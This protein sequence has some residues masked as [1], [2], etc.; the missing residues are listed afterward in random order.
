MKVNKQDKITLYSDDKKMIGVVKK[1]EMP[2]K[3]EKRR[4]IENYDIV[5]YNDEE[6]SGNAKQ[7]VKKIEK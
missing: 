3:Q 4:T 7:K 2:I 1:I 5:F 6:Y